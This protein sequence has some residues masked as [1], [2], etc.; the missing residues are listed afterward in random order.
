M[1]AFPSKRHIAVLLDGGGGLEPLPIGRMIWD[2]SR[3][4]SLFEFDP[5]CIADRLDLSP[6]ALPLKAGSFAAPAVPFEGL[7]GLFAD[8]LPDG[9]GRRLTDKRLIE[10]NVNPSSLTPVDRL[11]LV[12]RDGM[13][14]LTYV[15]DASFPKGQLESEDLDALEVAADIMDRDIGNIDLARLDA[16]NGGS[17]GARPKVMLHI[18]ARGGYNNLPSLGSQAWVV[19]F[20][21]RLDPPE[22]GAIEAAYAVMAREAGVTMAETG[23]IP[24][25]TEQKYKEGKR[26]VIGLSTLA[27]INV[28]RNFLQRPIE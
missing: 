26:L 19:K 3:R 7:F 12:G 1:T 11:A 28:D 15:P 16:L 18:D 22:I 27:K 10:N 5:T 8:S 14:A 13:G 20:A 2:A 6:I 4:T 9:W 24:A 25:I 21:S 23:F 17:A